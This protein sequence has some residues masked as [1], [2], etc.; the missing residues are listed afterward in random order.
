M[1]GT[2]MSTATRFLLV[3]GI[4]TLL[5]L[6]AT[7]AGARPAPSNH[8]EPLRQVSIIERTYLGF[9]PITSPT[10]SI[11]DVTKHE[12]TGGVTFF[13]FQVTVTNPNSHAVMVDFVT[14]DGTA[15]GASTGGIGDYL[16]TSGTLGI[17]PYSTKGNVVVRVTAD[18][19]QE[20]DETFFV[21]LANP[22]NGQIADDQGVGLIVND[23]G[24]PAGVESGTVTDF[25]LGRITP[26][27]SRGMA[28]F[29]FA[30]P[31]ASWIRLAVL[32]LQGREVAVLA[33]GSHSSGRHQGMWNGRIGA[34]AAPAGVYFLR[35]QTPDG[36]RMR[37]IILQR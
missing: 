22:V 12:G 14:A 24:V 33:E 25:A 37:R 2:E 18:A 5:S 32:D 6:T 11:G 26:T 35:Y 8:T 15:L 27:P 16:I 29:E 34:P 31:R 1:C 9:D 30:L 13:T 7:A 20:S 4:S 3:T 21:R 23:D 19:D 10:L 17:G 28:R 36:N